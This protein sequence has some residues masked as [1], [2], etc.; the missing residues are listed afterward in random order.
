LRQGHAARAGELAGTA[1]AV[2]TPALDGEWLPALASWRQSRAGGTLALLVARRTELA[3]PLAL[4]LAA[5]GVAA[6]TFEV[7]EAL[8][9]LNPAKRKITERVS[10][11]GKVMRVG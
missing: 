10:P 4:R 1:L 9:L 8:P 2:V 3:Q 5:T 6:H 11:L 7:G